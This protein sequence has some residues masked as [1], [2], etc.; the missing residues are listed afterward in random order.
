VIRATG[1]GVL[2]S[3]DKMEECRRVLVSLG[4]YQDLGIEVSKQNQ[5]HYLNQYMEKSENNF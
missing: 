5:Y 4:K 2:G 3:M 1:F